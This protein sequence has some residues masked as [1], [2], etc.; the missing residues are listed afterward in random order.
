MPKPPAPLVRKPS[1]VPPLQIPQHALAVA[2]PAGLA[3][4]RG[5][6]AGVNAAPVATL[7][8]VDT[9]DDPSLLDA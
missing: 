7:G 3:A 9:L 8:D 2:V 5:E 4:A 6:G 1:A